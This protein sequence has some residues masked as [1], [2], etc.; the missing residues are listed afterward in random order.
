MVTDSTEKERHSRRR[1]KNIMA[2]ILRDPGERKGA[3]ALRIVNPKKKEY[4]REKIDIKNIEEFND[5]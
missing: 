1:R 4:K 5:D 3:F 2:K